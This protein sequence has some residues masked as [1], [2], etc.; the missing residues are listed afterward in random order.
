MS[1]EGRRRDEVRRGAEAAA[2]L[3]NPLLKEALEALRRALMKQWADSD[4]AEERLRERVWMA[5]GILGKI[6]AALRIHAET[7]RLAA[8]QLDLRDRASGKSA[9]P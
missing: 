6:E 2:L 5:V 4:G 9:T 7:G 3:E 8:E 1:D